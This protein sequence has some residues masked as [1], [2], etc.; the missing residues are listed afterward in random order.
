M[1]HVHVVQ[2]RNI[3]NVVVG[4][5]IAMEDTWK[6][7]KQKQKARI[8]NIMFEAVCDI[9][10]KTNQMPTED[11][12]ESLARKVYTR[13]N[14]NKL[15]F[16]DLLQVFVKKQGRFKE[17][18]LEHGL[19]EPKLIRIKKTEA[20]KLVIKRRQ[21]KRKKQ[22]KLELQQYESQNSM[23][24]NDTFCYIAGYTSNGVSYGLK[25]W[26]VG[27]DQDLPFEEKVR[28]YEEQSMIFDREKD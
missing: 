8:T 9:Y 17:R 12:Y 1:I 26:E 14:T 24:Q 16:E 21:R 28:L 19:P 4:D 2:E 27:I 7:L 11:Q 13:C 3:R 15:V 22:K 20:E 10:K 25:W 18:I 23:V 5:S 6:A